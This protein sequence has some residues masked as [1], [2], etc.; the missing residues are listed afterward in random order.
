MSDRLGIRQ[1]G[2]ERGIGSGD[3][4]RQV[5]SIVGCQIRLLEIVSEML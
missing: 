2:S 4:Q 1:A 3:G 5:A